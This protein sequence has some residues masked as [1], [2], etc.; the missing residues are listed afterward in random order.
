VPAWHA[1]A[2]FSK[3][4]AVV[5]KHPLRL[6]VR[7]D[8]LSQHGMRVLHPHPENLH[9]HTWWLSCNHSVTEDFRRELLNASLLHI[10]N[11]Q[12]QSINPDCKISTLGVN[13]KSNPLRPT[14]PVVAVFIFTSFSRQ[15]F[16]DQ[17]N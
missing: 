3:P 14:V 15:V 1:Q 17:Y 9:L 5:T 11:P 10:G 2:W 6:P 4:S 12:D 16:L 7:L 13:R 8:L